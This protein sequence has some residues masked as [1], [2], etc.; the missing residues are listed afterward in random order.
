[1]AD[2]LARMWNYG[3]HRKQGRRRRSGA[4][5]QRWWDLELLFNSQISVDSISALI[6]WD[7]LGLRPY[8]SV[9]CLSMT[10]LRCPGTFEK[11][12]SW[13][14]PGLGLHSKPKWDGFHVYADDEK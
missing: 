9:T 4:L 6:A 10:L 3:K 2:L 5:G 7:V 12:R 11:G 14:P 8:R 1:M 13:W